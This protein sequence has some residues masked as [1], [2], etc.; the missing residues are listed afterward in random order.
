MGL[1]VGLFVC[2]VVCLWG[3]LFVGLFV[4]LFV[5]GV[6]CLW[7]S[8]FSG[9]RKSK[10]GKEGEEIF[11]CGRCLWKKGGRLVCKCLLTIIKSD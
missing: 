6:V 11:V 9:C 10:C 1:F 7:G 8:L 5:C 3:C 2:R 4:G